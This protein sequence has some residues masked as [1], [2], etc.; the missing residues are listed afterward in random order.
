MD[1]HPLE[2]ETG[3]PVFGFSVLHTNNDQLVMAKLLSL[4]F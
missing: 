1:L 4:I 3:I 2:E